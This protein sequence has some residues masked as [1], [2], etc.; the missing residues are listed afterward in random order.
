MAFTGAVL[1]GGQSRRM[2]RDKAF[3][4]ARGRPLAMAALEALR[5]AGADEVLSIGG[6]VDRLARSGFDAHP[7]EYPGAG[8]LGGVVTALGI[9][10]YD[11][12]VVL[13]CDLPNA[14]ADE[15][16]TLVHLAEEHAEADIVLPTSDGRRQWLHAAYRRQSA[17]V[18]RSAFDAGERA[19]HRAAAPLAVVEIAA[20]DE[21]ALL[22]A[23]RPEDLPNE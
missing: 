7:D 19:L 20:R 11:P 18:L 14:S 12:V 23:D 10:R 13:A 2:G 9:A 3:V 21:A 5:G 16:A 22:D 8:P 1:A 4:Q 17:G 6:A 15:V